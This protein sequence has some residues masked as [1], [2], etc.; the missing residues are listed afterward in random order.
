MDQYP[1]SDPGPQPE[2]PP[3]SQPY[4]PPQ[5]QP[6]QQPGP[7]YQTPPGQPGLQQPGN[8]YEAPPPPP[9]KPKKGFNWLM[10]CGITCG[11]LLILVI[12]GGIGFIMMSK[13]FAEWGAA[14]EA[15]ATDVN[16][17]DPQ[18]IRA[19]A[20]IV[21]ARV[22]AQNPELYADQWVGV[23]GI[24]SGD[25][26]G[27]ANFNMGQ[28]GTQ[29]TTSYYLEGGV[30]VMDLSQM[31]R[32]GY[33]GDMIRAYGKAVVFDMSQMP[34]FGKFIEKALAEAAKDDPT[35]QEMPV[36]MVF[37]YTRDVELVVTPEEGGDASDGEPPSEQTMW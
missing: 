2:A 36:K 27:N 23:E 11:C 35:L 4:Q 30:L 28:Y 13:N 37:V 9:A 26:S 25:V 5:A 10:C 20:T 12:I 24:V 8:Y 14:F 6:Y 29:N 19:E 21:D 7:S 1:N 22:L 17:T 3:A 33:N 34:I 32:V 15:A 31:P 18:Q 16:N